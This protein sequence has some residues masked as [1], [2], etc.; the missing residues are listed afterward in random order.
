MTAS[1]GNLIGSEINRNKRAPL[2]GV[3]PI[4][5]AD[6]VGVASDIHFSC[7]EV[8]GDNHNPLYQP[9]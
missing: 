2:W 7:W 9:A 4:E 8:Y 6:G 3:A 5:V 1:G